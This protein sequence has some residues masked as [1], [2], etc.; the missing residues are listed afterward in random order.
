VS[1]NFQD[2]VTESQFGLEQCSCPCETE[3]LVCAAKQDFTGVAVINYDDPARWPVA[4]NSAIRDHI[5]SRG[6]CAK[7]NNKFIYPRDS[8]NRCFSNSMHY[9]KTANGESYLRNWLVYSES[10]NKT[11]CI[12]CKLFSSNQPKSSLA[13]DGNCNWKHL[14]EYLRGHENSPQHLENYFQWFDMCKRLDT[15]N[16]IDQEL[17]HAT[18]KERDYWKLVL[19]RLCS[20][21]LYLS[22]DNLSLRGEN[23]KLCTHPK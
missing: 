11:L 20:I 18:V 8:N 10:S 17:Q 1:D 15:G 2:S 12:C 5:V 3:I 14:H 23:D 13:S 4:F 9:R 21:V 6:L 19:Y 7:I 16:T 22:K